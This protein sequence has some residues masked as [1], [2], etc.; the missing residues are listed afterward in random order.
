[1]LQRAKRAGIV[2]AIAAG[3]EGTIVDGNY[4]GVKPLAENY[5]TALVA[6]PSSNEDS[7][8][9]AA[10]ENTKKH[11]P[12]VKWVDE[13][14]NKEHGFIVIYIVHR[15]VRK[16]NRS[17]VDV[18]TG[19]EDDFRGKNFAGKIVLTEIPEKV[20]TKEFAEVIRKITEG[21]PA[22]IILYN[23]EKMGSYLGVKT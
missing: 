7:I 10:M 19:T 5:D 12:L 23:T 1:M 20:D 21:K 11:A 18:Y 17:I 22:A 3:N 6:S 14:G 4:Y 9:V 8:S 13:K 2:V 15:Q 16:Y